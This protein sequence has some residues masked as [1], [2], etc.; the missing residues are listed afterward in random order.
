VPVNSV[1]I[2]AVAKRPSIRCTDAGNQLQIG[3]HGA[4]L[5]IKKAKKCRN[6]KKSIPKAALHWYYPDRAERCFGA[7]IEIPY[8]RGLPQPTHETNTSWQNQVYEKT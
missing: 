5:L 8:Q 4:S 3:V 7:I 1:A 6:N 2:R